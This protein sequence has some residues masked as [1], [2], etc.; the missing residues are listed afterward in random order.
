MA[1]EQNSGL[2]CRRPGSI[3]AMAAACPSTDDFKHVFT[4]CQTWK[5]TS[6]ATWEMSPIWSHWAIAGAILGW[7]LTL[8]HVRV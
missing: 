8:N 3:R 1:I 6:K 5:G 2:R 4:P 7:L